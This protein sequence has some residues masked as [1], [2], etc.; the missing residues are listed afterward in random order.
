MT[1][2][3]RG[4][5]TR[6]SR[7]AKHA[8]VRGNVRVWL[9]SRMAGESSGAS[10]H[11]RS[12]SHAGSPPD[13]RTSATSLGGKATAVDG[14]GGVMNILASGVLAHAASATAAVLAASAAVDDRRR[15]A[16]GVLKIITKGACFPTD[17]IQRIFFLAGAPLR[18]PI[19]LQPRWPLY[20]ALLLNCVLTRSVELNVCL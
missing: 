9:M 6:E 17:R 1:T 19:H 18:S 2:A 11:P 7:C 5:S 15:K 12:L 8:R 3:T 13:S 16:R 20:V 4:D 10:L 14:E